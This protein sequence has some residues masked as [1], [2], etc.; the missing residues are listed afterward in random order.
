[1][2]F[3]FIRLLVCFISMFTLASC[4]QKKVEQDLEKVMYYLQMT[5][6]EL[7][8]GMKSVEYLKEYQKQQELIFI[9]TKP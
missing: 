3:Y 6:K 2:N 4:E 5:S 9:K 7:N 1:M 8:N